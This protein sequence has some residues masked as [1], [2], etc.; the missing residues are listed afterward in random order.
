MAVA[1]AMDEVDGV[2]EDW[3]VDIVASRAAIWDWRAA[4]RSVADMVGL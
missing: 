4:M 3:S 2:R 1:R